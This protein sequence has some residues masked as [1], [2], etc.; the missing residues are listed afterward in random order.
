MLCRKGWTG[1]SQQTMPESN[2]NICILLS[3]F[4]LYRLLHQTTTP[5][6]LTSVSTKLYIFWFLHQTTTRF[7]RSKRIKRCIS[8]DSYIKPQLCSVLV[9]FASVVYLL[10]PTSNHNGVDVVNFTAKL[11]IFWFLHQTTT[12]TSA[13]ASFFPL[14]IFWFLHQTTTCK[15]N[16]KPRKSCISFDSYIK[17]QPQPRRRFLPSRCI[18]FDSYIKPQ[19]LI[20]QVTGF[21]VVY[22][23]IPTSNHN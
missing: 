22:L 2:S 20:L 8:F 4:R 19:R 15:P 23:L 5:K 11:Y 9:Y 3:L 13:A 1:N 10:I 6:G 21:I 12:S 18:S 7:N 14:Y 17:P 16:K